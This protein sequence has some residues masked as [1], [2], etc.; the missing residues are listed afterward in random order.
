MEAF[1]AVSLVGLK[2]NPELSRSRGE[3]DWPLIGLTRLIGSDG[4]GK[5][6]KNGNMLE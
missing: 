4:C 3:G 2:L 5:G 1:A 6:W